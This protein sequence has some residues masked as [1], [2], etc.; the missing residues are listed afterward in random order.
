MTICFA[1]W[2]RFIPTSLK[3]AALKASADLDE[4]TKKALEEFKTGMESNERQ[5]TVSIRGFLHVN[6]MGVG[7]RKGVET[8]FLRRI[9]S[10]DIKKIKI[11]R[12]VG[13]EVAHF[14][15]TK[16]HDKLKPYAQLP[17]G[18]PPY[19]C[20]A[21]TAVDGKCDLFLH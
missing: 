9:L 13:S 7:L 6:S 16:F 4:F 5:F 21:G 10:T 18:E 14:Y 1:E 11:R 2:S 3:S 20:A 12:V 8:K 15:V 17:G 19:S